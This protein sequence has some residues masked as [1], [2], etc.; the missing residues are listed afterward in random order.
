MQLAAILF[1]L[2]ALGGAALA[3]FPFRNIPRPPLWLALGH[4]A[5]AVASFAALLYVAA[6]D[7]LA[8]LALAA[9][10][11]LILAALGGATLLLGFHLRGAPL[12]KLLVAGHGLVALVGVVL[13]WLSVMGL[14]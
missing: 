11:V 12:P 1:T 4:G 2:T 9:L 10:V 6:T 3:S 8:G 13:L 5:A 14:P 7:G